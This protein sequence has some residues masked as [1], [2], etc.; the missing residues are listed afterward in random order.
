MDQ[1]S[2]KKLRTDMSRS[3]SISRLLDVG[4][5]RRISQRASGCAAPIQRNERSLPHVVASPALA[6]STCRLRGDGMRRAIPIVAIVVVL[7]VLSANPALA[8]GATPS[9]GLSNVIDNLRNWVVGLLAALATLFLTVGGVRY[10]LAGGDPGQVER[11]KSALRS[12]AIGYAF[13]ALAPMLIDILR[14]VVG[15]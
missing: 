2:L 13:A 1:V 15:G 8:A 3:V 11:A 14:S 7:I 6:H 10:M 9:A 5:L 12:A 4:N